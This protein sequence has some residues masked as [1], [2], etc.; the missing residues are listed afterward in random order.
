MRRIPWATVLQVLGSVAVL[1]GVSWA[2]G[3]AI[4]CI[5]A[6]L[7]AVGLGVGMEMR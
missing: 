2:F 7:A 3:Y 6:G 1:F 5:V 4:G